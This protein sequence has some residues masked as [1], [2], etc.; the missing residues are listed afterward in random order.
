MFPGDASVPKDA[1][2]GMMQ[3]AQHVP[4]QIQRGELSDRRCAEQTAFDH[5]PTDDREVKA[6]NPDADAEGAAP[7]DRLA[8]PV[9]LHGRDSVDATIPLLATIRAGGFGLLFLCS[10]PC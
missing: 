1:Q 5:Q 4:G 10:C 8:V 7:G 2:L 3:A 9:G 6:H